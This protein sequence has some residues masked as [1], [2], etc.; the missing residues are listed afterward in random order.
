[1][2]MQ[3]SGLEKSIGLFFNSFTQGIVI[4][5]MPCTDCDLRLVKYD[6]DEVGKS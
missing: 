5:C 6:K 1:M 2:I 3:T 4:K